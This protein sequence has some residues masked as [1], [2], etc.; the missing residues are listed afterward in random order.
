MPGKLIISLDFELIW[1]VIDS[2]NVV[3]YNENITG[4]VEIRC[5]YEI[6]C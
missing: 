6:I 1:G 5:N 3:S 2:S 4:L